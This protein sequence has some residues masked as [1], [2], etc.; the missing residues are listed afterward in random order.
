MESYPYLAAI[1]SSSDD[2]IIGKDLRGII[3]SWNRAA[4]AIFGFSI[5]EAL[6]QPITIL[7][8]PDFWAEEE[9]II[10]QIKQGERV[11]HFETV[12]RTKDG[13]E[14]PISLKVSPIYSPDGAVIGASKIARDISEAKR[15]ERELSEARRRTTEWLGLLDALQANAPV[16]VGFLNPS[17][18]YVRVNGALAAIHQLPIQDH[19]G[20][21]VSD[22]LPDQWPHLAAMYRAVIKEGK[23]FVNV[24]LRA[25]GGPLPADERFWLLSLF[26][27]SV[28]D[29]HIGIGEII[30]DITDRRVIEAELAQR[31]ADAEK[32]LG[33]RNLLLQEV[34]HRVKNNLQIVDGLLMMDSRQLEDPQ[35]VAALTRLRDRIQALALVHGQLMT[36]TDLRTFNAA[37][38]LEELSDNI[39]GSGGAQQ[40]TITVRAEPLVVGLD[41]A[42]PLGLVVTELVNNSLKHASF[43]DQGKI[44][45][46]LEQREPDGQIVLR[47]SDNG[48]RLSASE[49]ETMLKTFNSGWGIKI[50]EGLVAQLGGTLTMTYE[51]G[52]QTD[53]RI[54]APRLQ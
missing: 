49:T 7:I 15:I 6:G 31:T 41:F 28:L 39:L 53:I 51:Q 33:E 20:R 50:I 27:V 30:I 54:D 25:S 23:S 14:I 5:D 52:M 47:V 35:A 12:R 18:R 45:V 8:P 4:S 11:E 34:Y 40:A 19:I 44:E 13:R 29:E 48:K 2:A 16:G 1:I 36:S 22:V 24:E 17:Y 32:A 42:I 46:V 38:F 10:T 21:T 3:T 26:P 9:A 43:L 37:V